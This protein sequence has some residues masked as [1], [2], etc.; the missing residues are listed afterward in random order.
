MDRNSDRNLFTLILST[1]LLY[2][3]REECVKSKSCNAMELCLMEC[4][5][6]I[7]HE[8]SQKTA[9]KRKLWNGQSSFFSLSE[10]PKIGLVLYNLTFSQ[11]SLNSY[12]GSQHLMEC[13]YVNSH[14]YSKK[15]IKE[16]FWM[17]NFF[18]RIHILGCWQVL[19]RLETNNATFSQNSFDL[20]SFYRT[21]D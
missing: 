9:N 1:L 12:L 16:N 10:Y 15:A 13:I 21:S 11:N 14:E 17:V 3:L 8:Y 6:V 4:I 2:I 7:S 5:F 19:I 20:A 18:L